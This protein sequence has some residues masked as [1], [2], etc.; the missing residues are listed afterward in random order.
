[1]QSYPFCGFKQKKKSFKKNLFISESPFFA[2]KFELWHYMKILHN[3][4][5]RIACFKKL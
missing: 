1:M 2:I 5:D 4:N 3:S